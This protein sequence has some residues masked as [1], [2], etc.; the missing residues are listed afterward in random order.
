MKKE[1]CIKQI[2]EDFINKIILTE[3]EKEVL[4][5]YI[6]DYS[7]LK[8]AN[9][10]MQSTATVSRIIFNIKEKYKKYKLLEIEKLKILDNKKM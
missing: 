9:E 1:L 6:K 8:I 10:T 5:M 7:I 2:Y 3:Q 4:I